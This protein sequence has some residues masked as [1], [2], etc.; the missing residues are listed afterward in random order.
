MRHSILERM[1]W[2]MK[3]PIRI[4]FWEHY[5]EEVENMKHCEE[6]EK[7]HAK[8]NILEKKIKE[9]VRIWEERCGRITFS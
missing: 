1:R 7:L 8:V 5:W 9:E 4:L 3:R 2:V 6:F